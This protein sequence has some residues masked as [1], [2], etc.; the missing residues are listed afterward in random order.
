M[1]RTRYVDTS[2]VYTGGSTRDEAARFAQPVHSSGFFGMF[3]PGGRVRPII[4]RSLAF[5]RKCVLVRR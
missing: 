3:N 1:N 4:E 5:E 2:V